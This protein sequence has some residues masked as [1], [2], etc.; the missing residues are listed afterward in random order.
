MFFWKVG[1]ESVL[2]HTQ[3]IPQVGYGKGGMYVA[4]PYLAKVECFVRGIYKDYLHI[5]LTKYSDVG[6]K[7][8]GSWEDR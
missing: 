5:L 7:K 3:C 8:L 2:L 4:L 1:A 6:W